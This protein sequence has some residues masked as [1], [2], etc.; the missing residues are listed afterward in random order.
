MNFSLD[1]Q[2]WK[3]NQD[4]FKKSLLCDEIINISDFIE[5]LYFYIYKKLII[6]GTEK[7]LEI[8][9]KECSV[10]S[11]IYLDCYAGFFPKEHR[12]KILKNLNILW[13]EDVLNVQNNE[14]KEIPYFLNNNDRIAFYMTMF[15]I[16]AFNNTY[17]RYLPSL[18]S[19]NEKGIKNICKFI[20]NIEYC[21]KYFTVLDLV[22]Y[23]IKINH[24]GG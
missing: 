12:Y 20:K 10:L 6:T 16:K 2:I 23:Y 22:N 8:I 19:M 3:M 21:G 17:M 1:S 15:V 9:R 13:H 5:D 4:I 24:L 14:F 18:M 7:V 11:I